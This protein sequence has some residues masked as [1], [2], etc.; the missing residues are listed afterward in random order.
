MNLWRLFLIGCVICTLSNTAAI[1]QNRKNRYTKSDT[2]FVFSPG[3][4]LQTK[5]KMRELAFANNSTEAT[6]VVVT[7]T[8]KMTGITKEICTE[9]P[10]I[11]GGIERNSGKE[12]HQTVKS[13]HL[14]FNT[15]SALTNIG[16]NDYSYADLLKYGQRTD[17]KE[18]INKVF[19][20]DK[21]VALNF[22]GSRKQQ[23]MLAHILF[24]NGILSTR[25]DIAGNFM[26]LTQV[27][28]GSN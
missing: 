27:K 3:V 23:F 4:D 14:Y 18:I 21:G 16:F 22:K 5:A 7:A 15:T 2:L 1:S 20:S 13:A 11:H 25:G 26:N 24:N 12:R 17:V 19:K 8:N 28:Q 10:F 9:A 6:F